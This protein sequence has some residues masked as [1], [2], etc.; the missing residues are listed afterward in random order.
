MT[1]FILLSS[2]YY[3]ESI[4][5]QILN[6]AKQNHKLNLFLK[7]SLRLKYFVNLRDLTIR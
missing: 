6:Y 7:L 2:A 1:G 5:L 4:C 3:T